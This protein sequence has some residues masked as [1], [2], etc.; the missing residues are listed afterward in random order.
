MS[1]KTHIVVIKIVRLQIPTHCITRTRNMDEP[2]GFL[3]RLGCMMI[4]KSYEAAP[5]PSVS[6]KKGPSGAFFYVAKGENNFVLRKRKLAEKFLKWKLMMY[7]QHAALSSREKLVHLLQV[8]ENKSLLVYLVIPL[9]HFFGH[10]VEVY[11]ILA[12]HRWTHIKCG[13]HCFGRVCSVWWKPRL[14]VKQGFQKNS[15]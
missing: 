2:L 4:M 9:I 11:F 15:Q 6:P 10:Y 3:R 12:C 5:T 14:E 13:G 1:F 7:K 8:L